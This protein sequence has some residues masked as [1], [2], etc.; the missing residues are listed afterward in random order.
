MSIPALKETVNMSSKTLQVPGCDSCILPSV[1][2]PPKATA[3]VHEALQ[4]HQQAPSKPSWLGPSLP[5]PSTSA[6]EV[7]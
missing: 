1:P 7:Y 5:V 4:S 3:S 2:S 6:Q